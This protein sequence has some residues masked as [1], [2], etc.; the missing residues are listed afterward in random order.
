M[1]FDPSFT[2]GQ[3]PISPNIVV[4]TD[5]SAGSDAAITSRR[6]FIQD[7]AGN[8]LVPS[9]TTT[10]YTEWAYSDVSISL[11][12]L[13]QNTAVS[14]I[15]QWIDING[16]VLYTDVQYGPFANYGKLFLYQL[17]Q[18]QAATPTIPVDTNYD[19]NTAI[20]WTAVLGGINAIF[21]NNDIAAAQNSL[22]RATY[23]QLNQA[24]AF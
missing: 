8:Y 16:A 22:N 24:T 23:L 2:L 7:A 19:A 21:V 5:T 1:A 20:L 6:I 14:A 11:N 10:N 4:A 13:S 12:I 9:G 3:A 17:V 15:T 18:Q